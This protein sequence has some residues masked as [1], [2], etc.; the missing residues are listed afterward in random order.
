MEK[1]LVYLFLFVSILNL[2]VFVFRDFFQYVPYTTYNS[3]YD[4]CDEDCKKSWEGPGARYSQSELAAGRKILDSVVRKL[5]PTATKASAIA[6]FLY[7]RFSSQIGSPSTFIQTAEPLQQY[8]SLRDDKNQKLWCGN[9]GTM[10]F[11]FCR[12]ENIPCRTIEIIN[13][14]QNHIVNEF[15]DE[16]SGTWV[17]TDAMNNLCLLKNSSGKYLNLIDFIKAFDSAAQNPYSQM[18]SG[19]SSLLSE[20]HIYRTYYS[21]QSILYYY[22]DFDKEAVYSLSEKLKRYFLPVSWY[23]VYSKRDKVSFLFFCKSALFLSWIVLLLLII[24][25]KIASMWRKK[26]YCA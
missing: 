12:V 19:W 9:F 8:L 2:V 23:K 4:P 20:N 11:F 21:L 26:Y 5:D 18:G 7:K 1:R 15:Y 16:N 24:Q 17:F 3:L 6:S 22:H 13:K 10:F 14:G 25:K